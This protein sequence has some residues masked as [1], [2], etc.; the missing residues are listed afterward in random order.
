MSSRYWRMRGRDADGHDRSA[1][2]WARGEVGIWYGAWSAEDWRKANSHAPTSPKEY[3][4]ELPK[5]RELL[6]D[7]TKSYV[8]TAHRFESIQ[9][10][11]WVVTCFD[12]GLHLGRVS[13]AMDSREGHPLNCGSELFKF[14]RVT[15]TKA[16]RLGH[17]PDVYRLIPSAG[18]SNVYQFGPGYRDL[19]ALLARCDSERDIEEAFR[20]MPPDEWLDRLGPGEWES[21][22]LGYLIQTQSYLPTGLS[23]GRT[24]PV[25]DIVGVNAHTGQK[26]FA[27][28][29]KALTSIAPDSE[30]LETSQGPDPRPLVYFFA[31][32]GSDDC[33][34]WVR[35]VTRDT[36][37]DW[38]LNEEGSRY[39]ELWRTSGPV[40]TEE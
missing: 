24:L 25:M 21:L 23:V 26:I 37:L 6:W 18:R 15:H 36:M 7:V 28:C 17:L 31:Y 16:F 10:P 33:P 30:F 38:L 35:V 12:G 5:Q 3:L 20:A 14:R 11:D 22:C 19:V 40:R 34:D 4:N 29:K 1:E 39:L 9:S 32:G 13:E 27:Q 8:D 2:A